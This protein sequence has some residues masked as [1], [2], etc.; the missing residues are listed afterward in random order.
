MNK[1]N[2]VYCP[3]CDFRLFDTDSH[4]GTVEIKCKQCRKVIWIPLYNLSLAKLK[5]NRKETSK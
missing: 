5:L 2:T 1:L 3:N 4:I